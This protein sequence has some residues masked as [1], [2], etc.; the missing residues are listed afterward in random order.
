MTRTSIF[1]VWRSPTG[2]TS[3]SWSTRSSFACMAGGISPISSSRIVPPEAAS[4]SPRWSCVAPVKAPR[5][6]P[7]SSLSRSD[8]GSAA[9]LTATKGSLARGLEAAT[10]GEIAAQHAHLGS[11]LLGRGLQLLPETRLLDRHR[12]APGQ[13]GEQGEI[14]VAEGSAVAAVHDLDHAE[15]ATLGRERRAEDAARAERRVPV[16]VGVEA[17]IDRR[18]VDAYRLPAAQHGTGDPL[19]GGKA[20]VGER[21]GHLR[22]LLG[23]VGEVELGSL[24]VEQQDRRAF[25][26]EHLAALADHE[27]DQLVEFEPRYEGAAEIVEQPEL[28]PFIE[29]AGPSRSGG[30]SLQLDSA[31]APACRPRKAGGLPRPARP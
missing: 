10:P 8:S 20:E 26:I 5:R 1:R 11:Q 7:K 23:D 31:L 16:D 19:V 9:Q 29:H 21:P 13:R 6:W 15:R 17:G 2:R 22:V 28:R 14:A 25:G 24:G 3:P 30:D 18:V 27:R 12:H 4:N